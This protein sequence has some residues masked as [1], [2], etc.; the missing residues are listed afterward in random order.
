MIAFEKTQYVKLTPDP[1]TGPPAAPPTAPQTI[2]ASDGSFSVAV[3]KR[4]FGA[5]VTAPSGVVEASAA[6]LSEGA[7]LTIQPYARMEGTIRFDHE[8]TGREKQVAIS[9]GTGLSMSGHV[10]PFELWATTDPGGRFVIERV[11][12]GQYGMYMLGL[13]LT[14]QIRF[15]PGTDARVDIDLTTRRPVAGRIEGV[16]PQ[17]HLT[18]SLIGIPI[19]NMAAEPAGVFMLGYQQSDAVMGADG[20][21]TSGPVLPGNYRLTIGI[22]AGGHV[23]RD[24][25]IPPAPPGEPST[26]VNIG[27]LKL[28]RTGS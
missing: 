12:P 1:R 15:D 8:P 16:K 11:P 3:P 4:P 14:G 2:T 27:T 26:P 21:F 17:A 24:V 19:R 23:Q 9:T 25:Q 10:A 13:N 20:A 7:T 18:L 28:R 5:V 6:D 22:Q